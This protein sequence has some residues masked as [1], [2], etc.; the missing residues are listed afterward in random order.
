M[1][2]KQTKWIP[3][4]ASIIA[5][6]MSLIGRPAS[7]VFNYGGWGAKTISVNC[8]YWTIGRALK[9]YRTKEIIIIV[10]GTCHEDVLIERNLVT[11]VAATPQVDGIIG[12]SADG[13]AVTVSGAQNVVIDGL[14]VQSAGGGSPTGVFVTGNGEAT[15]QNALVENNAN[16]ISA[17]NG[18]FFLVRDSDVVNN[19]TYGVL[20]TDGGNA[21]VQH[22]I[23]EGNSAAIGAFRGINLR[24]RGE[25]VIGNLASGGLSLE[26]FHSV[27]FR[28][29]NGTTI[30][31]GR[32]EFGN[33]T[34]ASLRAPEI[35]G[36]IG[37]FG[38]SRVEIRNSGTP[39]DEVTGGG[40]IN[41]SG[42]SQLN[43]SRSG[44]IADVG[45]INVHEFSSLNMSGDVSVNTTGDVHM[46][47]SFL[48]MGP[49]SNMNVGGNFIARTKA[50]VNVFGDDA[51]VN[52]AG[53]FDAVNGVNIDISG[54]GASLNV[55]GGL[56][57]DTFFSMNLGDNVSLN[58]I[59][60]I[61]MSDF[62]LLF[63]GN[64]VSVTGN[65]NFGSKAGKVT[66]SGD[67]VS[68]TGNMSFDQDSDLVLGQ[69]AQIVGTIDCNGGDVHVVT[70][71]NFMP[72]GFVNCTVIFL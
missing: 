13:A 47:R 53:D 43:F 29:D 14:R 16:G 24:L 58:V 68:Y 46:G 56:I 25:N 60:Q 39:S 38:G 65:M 11:L 71:P 15:I 51:S 17:N 20:L 21:R 36:G 57:G 26:L 64:D 63:G 5:V 7:A 52:V 19:S 6:S 30:F 12:Q 9:W 44:I 45:S 1:S 4:I 61:S 2:T 35:I 50:Q 32:A 18:G 69:D 33:L 66:L 40:D 55:A 70:F 67:N 34:N 42:N 23:I 48:N 8:A 27:D 37:V 41:V 72:G 62:I 3:V 49:G 28:Q 59:G 54:N 31:N 22:S 10:K